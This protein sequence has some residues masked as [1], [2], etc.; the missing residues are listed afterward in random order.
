MKQS[1][2]FILVLATAATLFSCRKQELREAR[3]SGTWKITRMI[4][5]V[6]SGETLV[7]TTETDYSA[8]FYFTDRG[9]TFAE[10]A[11]GFDLD[12]AAAAHPAF[13]T[14]L[15][16][17]LPPP[18]YDNAA[19]NVGT[20]DAHRLSFVRQNGL[21]ANSTTVTIKKVAGKVRS[22]NYYTL[23]SGDAMIHEEYIV[24]RL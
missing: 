22:W 23:G 16:D 7:S 20:D 15:Y 17:N 18:L 13:L 8:T 10:N 12:T 11:V 19:W 6:Y 9:N 21:G 5:T 3:F 2:I 24:K 4:R 1:R 14:E